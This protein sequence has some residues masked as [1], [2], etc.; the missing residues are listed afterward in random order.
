MYIGD[1]IITKISNNPGLI[2]DNNV[3]IN[4]NTKEL[5]VS[6]SEFKGDYIILNKNEVKKSIISPLKAL[7]ILANFDNWF[8]QEHKDIYNEKIIDFAFY[9]KDKFTK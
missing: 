7:I 3:I 2:I 5:L 1:F 8:Y 9:Y 6:I 4:E